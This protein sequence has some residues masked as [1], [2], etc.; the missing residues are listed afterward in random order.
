MS[1]VLIYETKAAL[2]QIQLVRPLKTSI[3]INDFAT[4]NQS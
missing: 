4:K 1:H 2:A 3:A